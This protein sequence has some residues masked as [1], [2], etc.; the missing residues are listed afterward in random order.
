MPETNWNK[1][2]EI[3]EQAV[4]LMPDERAEFLDAACGGDDS[5][6]REVEAMLAADEKAD[7]FI[8]TP[9]A[10]DASLSLFDKNVASN[11]QTVALAGQ[12]IGAYRI[13]REI[14]RGGMG[15]VFLAER[16]DGEFQR[17]VAV[18]IINRHLR[19]E[20]M[21]R[22][23]RQER[24]ILAALD[25]PN[26]ARLYDGGTTDDGS[27]YLI[28]EYVEGETLLE[29]CDENRLTVRQRLE[30]FEQI[31][32]AVEY[33]HR[34][35]VLHRDLKPSNILVKPDGTAKLLDFGIAKLDGDELSSQTK[36]ITVTGRWMMTPE[37]ASPEQARGETLTAASDVYSLGVILYKLVTGQPPYKF[38]SRAPH[39]I[40]RIICEESPASFVLRPSPKNAT[41]PTDEQR[42]K[43]AGQRTNSLEKIVLKALRKS[44]AERFQAAAELSA[45]IKNYLAGAAVSAEIVPAV[46]D[47]LSID[48]PSQN[49]GSALKTL[50]VLPLRQF[51]AEQQEDAE[52]EFLGVGLADALTTRLSNVRQI[53]VRPTSSVVQSAQKSDGDSLSLGRQLAVDYVL[54]GRIARADSRF[55][56]IIQLLKIDDNSVLWASR[57]DESEVDIFALQDSISEK[58]VAS[59]AP[60]LTEAEQQRLNLRGTQN[61]AAYEAYLRG[62]FQ[63]LTYEAGGI[64]ESIRYFQEAARLDP[65]FALA[66][67]GIAEYYNWMEVYSFLRPNECWTAAKTAARR[68][69]EL[70]PLLS[71]AYAA[72]AFAV[73]GHDWDFA[74]SERLYR[75]AVELNPN[76]PRAHEWF[77]FLLQTVGRN[78][79]A[80]GEM[81]I[82]QRLDPRSASHCAAHHYVLHN[83]RRYAE[84]EEMLRRGLEIDP[85]NIL[86]N[87]GFGWSS[88]FLGKTEKGIEA[89]R[90]A[91][92][93][94][95]RVSIYLT[96]LG[97]DLAI[98]ARR[99]EARKILR[100]MSEREKRGE[101]FPQIYF[102][103]IHAGLGEADAAFARLDQ[104]ASE[105]DHWMTTLLFD[106]RLD[107][108][109]SDSRFADYVEKI[110]P[111]HELENKLPAAAAKPKKTQAIETHEDKKPAVEVQNAPVVSRN[112]EGVT[113]SW[114]LVAIVAIS[115]AAILALVLIYM[116]ADM[117]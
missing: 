15:A 20:F 83:A 85:E 94:T 19:N 63:L 114:R 56:I 90:R 84:A 67:A 18:K 116:I 57:F 38:P 42:T 112:T 14:G 40:A 9:A 80:I 98:G 115:I 22:R 93:A 6:R 33:A 107:N 24:Q 104:S 99:A 25:H 13:E 97:Y 113:L 39:E 44:A 43:D 30:L 54:E 10:A 32:A 41:P 105:R 35:N 76:N 37:Y 87:H 58:V 46:D 27:P 61:A 68:A 5:L 109:R 78:D 50:A 110:R 31:C 65:N 47:R 7:D 52:S 95:N 34:Q 48:K 70:D 59:L 2:V 101:Y 66:H 71:E 23:F 62:R 3:F 82:A 55:R 8:E 36:E 64:T 100:E 29:Y 81:K 16:A 91:V 106:P 69:V 4:E 96:T 60:H 102:A 75:R 51:Y 73:W 12:K 108:L 111:L 21:I 28:M 117:M 26:I 53:I 86:C 88:P 17:R 74:E 11:T 45:E 79:E 72:L 77:S 1:I 103:V 92:E 49:S 89:A